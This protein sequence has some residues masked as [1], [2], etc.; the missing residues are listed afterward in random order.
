MMLKTTR[1]TLRAWRDNDRD[2]FAAMNADR[3]VMA[4]LG[5]P[6]DRTESD[7]KFDRYVA[8][9]ERDGFSRWAI[10]DSMG[11]FLGY[12]GVLH[13]GPGHPLGIHDEIGWRLV[14][15]A[16]GHGYATEAA[17][18]ALQDVFSRVGLREVVSYTSADNTRSCAVMERLG[19][20]RDAARDFS[21]PYGKVMWR[22]LVWVARPVS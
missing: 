2:V 16:W 22:G 8:A 11:R 12:A 7:T 10:E 1:L 3:T 18:A 13:S 14:R 20:E 4:D 9:F 5:G 21:A 19:L 17:R 15:E 6:L